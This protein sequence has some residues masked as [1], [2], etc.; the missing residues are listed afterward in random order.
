M[1]ENAGEASIVVIRS[2][3]HEGRV[4]VVYNTFDESANTKEDYVSQRDT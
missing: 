3:G 4:S 1:N 2:D